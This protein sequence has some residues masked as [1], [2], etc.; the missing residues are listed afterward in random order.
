MQCLFDILLLIVVSLYMTGGPVVTSTGIFN[1]SGDWIVGHETF[2]ATEEEKPAQASCASQVALFSPE[3]S[4]V[5]R[6]CEVHLA[7]YYCFRRYCVSTLYARQRNPK[8][9]TVGR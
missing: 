1:P 8:K 4:K 2:R 6:H 7:S 3:S 5:R 9:V